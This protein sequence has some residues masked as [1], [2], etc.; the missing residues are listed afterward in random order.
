[1]EDKILSFWNDPLYTTYL[2]YGAVLH[3]ITQ[4]RHDAPD[5]FD[6]GDEIFR[7]SL[8]D[9]LSSVQKGRLVAQSLDLIDLVARQ[10]DRDT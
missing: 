10:Q 1:M 6:A 9:D 4:R 3:G 5:T 7:R 8:G 2:S